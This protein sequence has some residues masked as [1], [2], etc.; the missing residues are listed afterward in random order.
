MQCSN[1]Q[2][3]RTS[4]DDNDLV[5]DKGVIDSSIPDAEKD[6]IPLLIPDISPTIDDDDND[7]GGATK[8]E[9]NSKDS[10]DR[11]D[12]SGNNGDD[13]DTTIPSLLPFP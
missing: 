13:L 9:G 11:D 7:D 3:L 4:P 10:S 6:E 8:R 1:Q 5:I 12:D 2:S